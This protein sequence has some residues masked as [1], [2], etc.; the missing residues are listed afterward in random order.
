MFDGGHANTMAVADGG[1]EARFIHQIIPRRHKRMFSRNVKA[2]EHDAGMGR[3]GVN[4]HMHGGT[5]VQTYARAGHFIAQGRLHRMGLV[6]AKIL[7]LVIVKPKP[8]PTTR[9][10]QITVC[11]RLLQITL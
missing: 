5:A 3:C 4:H 8:M 7:G 10:F 9:G 6:H 2:A 1:A 11:Y